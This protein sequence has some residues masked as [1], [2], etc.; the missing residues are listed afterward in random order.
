[1]NISQD[2]EQL[3]L[4]SIFHYVVGGITGLFSC[5]TLFYIVFG[6]VM[7]VAPEILKPPGGPREPA[8]EFVGWFMVAFGAITLTIGWSLAGCILFAGRCL[9]RRR[10]HMF[11]V[12]VAG[13][14]CLFM[15]FGTV[16]GV[17]TIVVLTRPSVKELFTNPASDE[18]FRPE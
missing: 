10:H 12:I 1:M 9:A 14:S 3:R 8:P 15:P 5:L 11:C 13:F 17:F 2:A 6:I 16:L 4:L 7:I 18:T